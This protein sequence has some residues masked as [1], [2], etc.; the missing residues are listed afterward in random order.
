MT[1]QPFVPFCWHFFHFFHYR[2]LIK[3]LNW[4]FITC[5][6]FSSTNKVLDT[7]ATQ[8]KKLWN[9]KVFFQIFRLFGGSPGSDPPIAARNSKTRVDVGAK[10]N[11][12]IPTK[13]Q[14]NI[15]SHKMSPTKVFKFWP[16]WDRNIDPDLGITE[17]SFAGYNYKKM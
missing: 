12:S 14:T 5:Q 8:N 15:I 6:L 2:H 13:V 3:V 10:N 1:N 17:W 4:Y 16:S 11:F 7:P 9:K